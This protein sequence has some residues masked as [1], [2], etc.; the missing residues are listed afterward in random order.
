MGICFLLGTQEYRKQY[1]K[2][3]EDG[4]WIVLLEKNG[5]ILQ[6][7]Y[8]DILLKNSNKERGEFRKFTGFCFHFQEYL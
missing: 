3:I 6:K 7:A 1:H 8:D 2:Y 5:D 4:A